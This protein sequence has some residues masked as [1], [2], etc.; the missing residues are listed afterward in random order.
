MP[1]AAGP[2]SHSKPESRATVETAQ[3]CFLPVGVTHAT[4]FLPWSICTLWRRDR[5]PEQGLTFCGETYRSA[6]ASNGHQVGTLTKGQPSTLSM[7]SSSTHLPWSG[8]RNKPWDDKRIGW[9]H[10]EQSSRHREHMKESGMGA[11][12]GEDLMDTIFLRLSEAFR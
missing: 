7:N 5:S 12:I 6:S 11:S 1:I 10:D 2:S 3:P 8:R 4:P 9:T